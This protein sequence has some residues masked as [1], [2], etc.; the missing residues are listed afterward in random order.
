MA[1]FRKKPVDPNEI[2]EAFQWFESRGV[3]PNNAVKHE[4]VDFGRA[5]FCVTTAHGQKAIVV[6]GD[7]IMAEPDGRGYYPIKPDIFA[8]R[9]E[10]VN[11]QAA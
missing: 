2:F 5:A 3:N 8:N 7:W 1:K 9:Y 11:E 6:D 10:R 4:L